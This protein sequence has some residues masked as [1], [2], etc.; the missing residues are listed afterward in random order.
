MLPNITADSGGEYTCVVSNFA[1][2]HNDSTF[3]FVYPYF[4][5]HP[6]DMQVS[7][8]SVLLLTCDALG[9]PSPD[10]LWQRTDGMQIMDDAVINGRVL[11]ITLES[12]D[13]GEYFCTASGRGII[14]QSQNA[15]VMVLTGIIIKFN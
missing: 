2:S 5:S 6:G 10:Y 13:G 7:F 8:G 12:G 11:N 4:L 1:G 9:F 3:L 15:F 14:I